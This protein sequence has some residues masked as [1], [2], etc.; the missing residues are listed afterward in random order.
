MQFFKRTEWCGKVGEQLLNKEV[1][2]SG[3]VH[4]RR[5]LG[6]I[7]FV[8]LRDRTGLMQLVFDPT[9]NPKI[10]EQAQELRSEFVVS[11]KGTVVHRAAAAVNDKMP[12]GRYEVRAKE[13]V[14]ASK[15]AV[16]PFQ[17]EDANISEE[18]RLKYRYLD[19]RNKKMQDFLRLRHDVIFAM[20][21]YFNDNGFVEV[22]TPILSKST[23]EGAR[24]FLVPCRVQPGTFY[25]LPQSPQ[26]YKQL[27]IVG[28][29]ERYFQIA[30]CFRDEALRAN[31]Q[32][33]FT[34][35]DIEMSFVDEHDIQSMCE[36]LFSI[37][38]K[39]FLTIELKLPLQRYTYDE[40][41]GRFGSDKP[42]M[43]FDLEIKDLTSLFESTTVNFLKSIIADHGK[44]GALCVSGKHFSRSELDNISNY[45][46]K[47]LGAKGLLWIRRKEDGSLDSA[48]AKNLPADF[49]SK[50]KAVVPELTDTDTLFVIAGPY[51]E[52]WTVLGQLRLT[53][54]KMLNLIN[55]TQHSMFWIT[56][57]PMFEWNKEENRWE[58]KH[59]PFTS[60]QVGW[61]T[62]DM[63]KIKARAYD[64]VYNGEELG[65]GSIRIHDAGVQSKVFSAL[66]IDPEKAK[67]KFGFLLEAQTY[68]YPPDGGI[69]FGIDR[70]VMM[71]A[72]TESIRD[73]IAFPKTTTGSCLM[74][75]T[76]SRV[77]AVQLK[78]LFLESTYKPKT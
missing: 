6:G 76:P 54:G 12:T 53:F 22:E 17:L 49:W 36:G 39:K 16:L 1:C 34:Q 45:V 69:A 7:I 40:V 55:T 46:S 18:L 59:H 70:L 64:L 4:K 52:A 20:R 13:L 48:I 15:S 38:W 74:M 31:R 73:V 9:N 30:R 14:I 67:E 21:Q 41:F 42:D 33:E 25:A 3:W 19:L 51:E 11:V 26:I 37:L 10:T 35:L 61:E 32:P 5:N 56:D 68:G 66:G 77:D 62:M 57:F 2:L 47:E 63:G 78:E 28:G 60:P 8:D 43:R 75:Q 27:L 23:P 29:L 65:G 72:G 71:L 50:A 58:A 24:D 44:V